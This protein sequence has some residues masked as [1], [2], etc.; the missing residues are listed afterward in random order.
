MMYFWTCSLSVCSLS[1]GGRRRWN[2]ECIGAR[3]ERRRS[4][5]ANPTE[6]PKNEGRGCG[7]DTARCDLGP[8]P[9][10][11]RS[12]RL[13][14]LGSARRGRRARCSMPQESS[15]VG[16]DRVVCSSLSGLQGVVD[17]THRETPQYRPQ[18][19][20]LG[21]HSKFSEIPKIKFTSPEPGSLTAVIRTMGLGLCST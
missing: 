16:R 12:S 14:C 1:S 11:R 21:S 19:R 3:K 13:R 8:V 7:P 17:V 20:S 18:V 9:R 2:A 10:R 5:S 15:R 6:L 4:V